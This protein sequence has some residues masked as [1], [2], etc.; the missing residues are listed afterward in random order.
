MASPLSAGTCDPGS[1]HPG[2]RF[3]VSVAAGGFA[4]GRPGGRRQ[5]VTVAEDAVLRAGGTT[6]ASAGTGVSGRDRRLPGSGIGG[7]TADRQTGVTAQRQAA[8]GNGL[9][10]PYRQP[11]SDRF[12]APAPEQENL[13]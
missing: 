6:A 13:Q 7:V 2:V 10:R 8:D 12:S 5:R 3:G 1:A 11:G 9:L 4:N